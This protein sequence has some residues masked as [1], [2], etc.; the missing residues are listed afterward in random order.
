MPPNRRRVRPLS[1]VSPKLLRESTDSMTALVE[2]R[3]PLQFEK[4]DLGVRLL[5][6]FLLGAG[7]S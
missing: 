3:L 5:M 7:L 6:A 2:E 1:K 4:D